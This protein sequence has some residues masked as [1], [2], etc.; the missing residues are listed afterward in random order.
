M[1]N[2]MP[3]KYYLDSD[4]AR[5]CSKDPAASK[6]IFSRAMRRLEFV[7]AQK[8]DQDNASFVFEDIYEVIRECIQAVMVRDGFKPYSH[9]A[10]VAFVNDRYRGEYG[11]KLINRFD[12]Y[13]IIRND[14]MYR[15]VV[16]GEEE[17]VKAANIAGDFV[18]ITRAVIGY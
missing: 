1:Q 17:T 16:I 8:V 14:S 15:A 4:L 6:A 9:E 5:Q 10:V 3:F 18:K 11:D 13:R 12:R 7:K 2:I